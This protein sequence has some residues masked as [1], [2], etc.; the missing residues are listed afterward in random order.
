MLHLGI[1]YN[2]Q[3]SS[4]AWGP[5]LEPHK[6]IFMKIWGWFLP[7]AMCGLGK[8]YLIRSKEIR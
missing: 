5:T 7:H 2:C 6:L 3:S 1:T 4:T 8:E